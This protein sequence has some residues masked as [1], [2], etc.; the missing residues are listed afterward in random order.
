MAAKKWFLTNDA[1]IAAN[2]DG[3]VKKTLRRK[4][5]FAQAAELHKK[6]PKA[7]AVGSDTGHHWGRD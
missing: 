3:F 5:V 2:C 7:W 1:I 6:D 4:I